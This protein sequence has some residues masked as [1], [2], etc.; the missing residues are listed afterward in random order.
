MLIFEIAAHVGGGSNEFLP[1]D[2]IGE[3]IIGVTGEVVGTSE[4]PSAEK[5][6]RVKPTAG[7]GETGW[8]PKSK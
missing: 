1:A 6:L 8:V 7:I 4:E 2:D 3:V 5:E